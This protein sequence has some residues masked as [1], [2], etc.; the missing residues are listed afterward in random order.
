MAAQLEK[1][2]ELLLL[3]LAHEEAQP[4]DALPPSLLAPRRREAV[5]TTMRVS[6][7]LWRWRGAS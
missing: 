6:R 7:W 4:I 1:G 3:V 2:V 5:A